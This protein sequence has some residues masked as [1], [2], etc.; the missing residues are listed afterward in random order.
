M[1]DIDPKRG[2][3]LRAPKDTLVERD[4]KQFVEAG[5]RVGIEWGP[6]RFI[7]NLWGRAAAQVRACALLKLLVGRLW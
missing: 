2:E 1:D 3:A 5:V 6:G 7:I 4:D